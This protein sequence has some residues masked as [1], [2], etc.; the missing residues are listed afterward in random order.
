MTTELGDI[1]IDADIFVPM[2]TNNILSFNA[3]NAVNVNASIDLGV[4][5][6]G[7][8]EFNSGVNG[9]MPGAITVIGANSVGGSDISLTASTIGVQNGLQVSETGSPAQLM[10]QY[11]FISG[12]TE[13][14]GGMLNIMSDRINIFG[15]LDA[16][17]ST[18]TGGGVIGLNAN[19]V[20]NI[21]GPVQIFEGSLAISGNQV[22][23]NGG[24]SIFGGDISI[25]ADVF[26]NFSGNVQVSN[27][28]LSVNAPDTI[29]LNGGLTLAGG[30]A[31]LN[32]NGTV[33]ISG[34]T[35]IAGGSLN[36]TSGAFLQNLVVSA[37]VGEVSIANFGPE[38]LTLDALTIISTA[39]T[40]PVAFEGFSTVFLLGSGNLQVEEPSFFFEQGLSNGVNF[41]SGSGPLPISF[42]GNFQPSGVVNISGSGRIGVGFSR[43]ANPTGGSFINFADGDTFSQGMVDISTG[44]LL[45]VDGTFVNLGQVNLNNSGVTDQVAIFGL[46]ENNSNGFPNNSGGVLN[47]GVGVDLF[48]DQFLL[49]DGE[50]R[51]DGSS[52][53][54]DAGASFLCY[55]SEIAHQ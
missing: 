12:L 13:V 20:V 18:S 7:T 47:I 16:I 30:E 31:N 6:G 40:Q 49:E 28:F 37:D 19:E 32:S 25:D 11:I 46:L 48:V 29:N 26:S 53:N 36:F 33:N 23:V 24:A 38:S 14:S 42:E 34:S 52:F 22:N 51:L 27:G 1:N 55:L 21:F 44:I 35:Q 50:L 8:I 39:S 17:G 43:F 45:G 54:F 10:A 4:D 15:N 2:G 41:S 5:S 9:F 3:T